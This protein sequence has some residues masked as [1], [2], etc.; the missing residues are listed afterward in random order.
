MA[1]RTGISAGVAG[2]W[3]IPLFLVSV[4]VLGGALYLL[5]PRPA[6]IPLAEAT[7]TLESLISGGLFEMAIEY[8]VP[9]LAVEGRSEAELAPVYLWLAR[10]KHGLA[11]QRG[12]KTAE[13]VGQIHEYYGIAQRQG[14]ALTPEDYERIGHVCEGEG[15][16]A[17]AVEQFERAMAEG[18]R[19]TADLRRHVLELR[20]Y[21]LGVGTEE[22]DAA[23]DD[24]LE[25]L[26]DERLD[27]R[28]WGL[29]Q[30]VETLSALGRADHAATL[31]A[32]ERERFVDS[33]LAEHFEYLEALLLAQTG[34]THE[35]EALLRSVRNRVDASSELNAMTGLLLGRV[36]LSDG[37]PQRPQ[38][39]LA[40]FEDVTHRHAFSP[41]TVASRVGAAEA[42]ALLERH[43]EAVEAY[44]TAVQ[45]LRDMPPS[46]VVSRDAVRVSLAVQAEAQKQKG[47]LE[48][49]LAYAELAVA[50]VER[51]NAEQA[52]PLLEQFGALQ[53][54]RAEE[55]FRQAQ[56]LS[57]AGGDGGVPE[58]VGGTGDGTDVSVATGLLREAEGLYASAAGTYIELSRL[59]TLNEAASAEA[60]WQ[61][62]ELLARAG[63]RERAAR[64]FDAF[65]RE[66]PTHVLV[67]RALLRTG[68][69]RQ[70]LG[71]F[72]A[73]IEAYQECYRRFPH[74]LDGARALVPLARCYFALGPQQDE[75]ACKTLQVVLDDSE[76]FTPEA[77][78]FAEALF[79]QGEVLNRREQYE[80]AIATLEEALERYPNDPRGFRARFV[81]ADSYRQS[82]LALKRELAEA[83]FAGEIEYIRKESAQR[84]I[85]ARELY[86]GLIN[87]FALRAPEQLSVMERMYYRHACLYEAD[88]FY[89]SREYKQ[90]LKLYE[91][92][93]A[94]FKDHPSGLAAYVQIVNCHAFLGQPAEARAALAR[95]QI[96]VEAMP[97]VSLADSISPVTRKDWERYFAWL[98]ESNFAWK[99]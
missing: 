78:E 26:D 91:E 80:R 2:K 50:L 95:A 89:E 4:T 16:L 39:A 12:D 21:G 73:A 90:A 40:F 20:R 8:G 86:R 1:D 99:E 33:D 76:L 56:D 15:K 35:A 88:C 74:S 28:L 61:A 41:Y 31:L 60:S 57:V 71:Q 70:A 72:T 37:G 59:N 75:L 43:E 54:A 25:R 27:L 30:K 5:R 79:L 13:T 23:L 6:S 62:A 38:E 85:E 14:C 92:A 44:R 87:E 36:V 55:L 83:K 97:A 9:L 64:L 53:A 84:F 7:S 34:Q 32:R 11:L 93:A 63:L 94:T 18:L 65:A 42:L 3:Q 46:S 67:A 96:L 98:G 45:E 48:A 10:A 49:A 82:A 58:A 22:M 69:L 29:Q 81:L 66:R 68:Q 47:R 24:F 52:A 17:D 77:A 19:N 51:S